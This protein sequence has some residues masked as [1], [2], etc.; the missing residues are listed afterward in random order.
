MINKPQQPQTRG[1]GNSVQQADNF[2]SLPGTAPVRRPA[3]EQ[4]KQVFSPFD[5]PVPKKKAAEEKKQ[6]KANAA[7]PI[8]DRD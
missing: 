7:K 1:K 6:A 3:P 5:D 8:M 2:P 4:K